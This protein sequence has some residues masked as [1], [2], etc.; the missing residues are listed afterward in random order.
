MLAEPTS[1][2]VSPALRRLWAGADSPGRSRPL[3]AHGAVVA[4]L[5]RRRTGVIGQDAH[6][7]ADR[8]LQRPFD[9]AV[10]VRDDAVLLVGADHDQ[11]VAVSTR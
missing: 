6:L 5:G 2:A 10:A 7:R 4:V 11:V 3:A 9:P 8:Q 1:R